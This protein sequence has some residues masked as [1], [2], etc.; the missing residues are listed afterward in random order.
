MW[1]RRWLCG[2]IAAAV[3]TAGW[4]G[5]SRADDLDVT[6]TTTLGGVEATTYDYD[7]ITI[8]PGAT[9]VLLGDVTL[10]VEGDVDIEGTISGSIL[11]SAASDG[12]DGTDG[13]DGPGE[14]QSGRPGTLGFGGGSNAARGINLTVNSGGTVTIN[15]GINLAVSG[16]DGGK[17]GGGG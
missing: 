12:A 1:D 17:G 3:V 9:L 16:A 8:A 4:A 11:G 14:G 2:L 15:G 5:A 7:A 6:G 13:E 10:N